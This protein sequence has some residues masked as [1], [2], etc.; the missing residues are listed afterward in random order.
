MEFNTTS[1]SDIDGP[2]LSLLFSFFLLLSFHFSFFF[3][4]FLFLS[5]LFSLLRYLRGFGVPTLL[6]VHPENDPQGKGLV[7]AKAYTVAT[8]GHHAGV[9]QS[10][11]VA[12]VKSDLMGEQTILCVYL[13]LLLIFF[14][15]G[16]LFVCSV[17]LSSLFSAEFVD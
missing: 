3:S 9:L 1:I 6:A 2:M 5:L 17:P 16:S 12:E 13:L 8:G 15:V 7:L 10:S 14:V 4:F 11:F